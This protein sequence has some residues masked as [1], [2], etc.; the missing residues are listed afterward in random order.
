MQ[1]D[2]D[3]EVITLPVSDDA[4]WQFRS[5]LACPPRSCVAMRTNKVVCLGDAVF[6]QL[7]K[8]RSLLTGNF[9]YVR[10][11]GHDVR[12]T[13]SDNR[14]DACNAWLQGDAQVP[15]AIRRYPSLACKHMHF[16]TVPSVW[17]TSLRG[18]KSMYHGPGIFLEQLL[19]DACTP[20]SMT[21]A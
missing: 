6:S 16:A 1:F 21:G 18:K 5:R 17:P 13:R 3:A 12:N 9:V 14:N 20:R 19:R 11:S 10:V 4:F 7:E 2:R 15:R 8:D